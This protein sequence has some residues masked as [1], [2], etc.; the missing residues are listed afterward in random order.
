MMME[1]ARVAM[2]AEAKK[3]DVITIKT[4]FHHIMETGYRVDGMGKFTATL[5][6]NASGL[7]DIK[8]AC[9]PTVVAAIGEAG[10]QLG[11]SAKASVDVAGAVGTN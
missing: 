8:A 5:S 11:A 1:P 4:L 9:I 7:A 2:P 3:G 10:G 6:A